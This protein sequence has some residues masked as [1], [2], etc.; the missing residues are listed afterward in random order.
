MKIVAAMSGGVDS[1]VAAALLKREGH[2]VIGATLQLYAPPE[3]APSAA[4]DARRTADKLGIPHY[5][6]DL[7]EEFSREIIAD[8]CAEYRRG[9]TPNPCVRCNRLFKFG[10]LGEKAREL[11]ADFLATGHYARIETDKITGQRILKKGLDPRKDQSYF[12]YRLTQ[13]QLGFTLF[14]LGGLTKQEVKQI[15]IDLDLPAAARPES[16][17]ICFIPGDD[18]AAF[19]DNYDPSPARPGPIIDSGEKVVGRHRGLRYFTVGQRKGLGIAAAEPLYVTAIAPERNAVIVGEKA[20]TYAD[21]LTADNLNWISG[22]PPAFPLEIKARVRYRHPEAEAVVTPRGNDSVYVKFSAPQM[23]VAP[24]QSVV[25]Y[26]GDRVNGGGT[27]S[28]QGR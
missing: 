18:Y 16:Q 11:G 6:F 3:T 15:A 24:G 10:R 19:L 22:D 25:F 20:Q 23:A 1:A 17:E 2:E 14:P 27:I 7:R 4:D 12:L 21:A 8:F 13:E 26:D 28:R 9:R 5:V